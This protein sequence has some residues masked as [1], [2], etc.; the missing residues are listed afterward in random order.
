M[1]EKKENAL[2]LIDDLLSHKKYPTFEDIQTHLERHMLNHS[3]KSVYRYLK[4]LKDLN[5]PIFRD[6]I[7]GKYSYTIETYRLKNNLI[8][9][10]DQI[11]IV[12][13][14]KSLLE[15][16]KDTPVYDQAHKLL[17]DMTTVYTDTEIDDYLSK[18]ET[19]MDLD[20]DKVIFLGP[21]IADLN[22][23]VWDA[24]Y[25]AIHKRQIITFTYQSMSKNKP[26]KRIA[27]PYQLIFDDGNWN[28]WCLDC[29]LNE[30]RTFTVSEMKDFS[31]LDGRPNAF[32]I[33]DDFDFREK[34][35]GA[36]GCYTTDNWIEYKFKLTGYAK[37]H[38]SNRSFG[39]DQTI[40]E[41]DDNSI[42]LTFTSNQ[43]VPVLAWA[44]KWGA[45]CTVLEPEPFR[46]KWRE[47]IKLM[48]N[49]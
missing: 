45:E 2:I 14:L 32:E 43:D 48:S 30:K 20:S 13:Q 4:E 27:A 42:T 8:A 23:D 38:A 18:E 49:L 1:S 19:K 35:L 44:L 22:K 36:F 7:T 39:K 29:R 21:P 40:T 3:Q 10:K 16:I 6:P 47:Q 41:N 24:I 12:S 26:E 5:A 34:T 11:K 17:S 28:V 15:S 46:K 25:T 33:P 9:P 31:L 37:R